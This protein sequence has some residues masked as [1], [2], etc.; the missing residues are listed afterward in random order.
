MGK[1]SS[2]KLL[3]SLWGRRGK[4]LC[5]LCQNVLDAK[6]GMSR[7]EQWLKPS[8]ASRADKKN[9]PSVTDFSTTGRKASKY[10]LLQI[11]SILITY[12]PEITFFKGWMALVRTISSGSKPTELSKHPDFTQF[13]LLFPHSTSEQNQHTLSCFDQIWHNFLQL[14]GSCRS[15]PK[16]HRAVPLPCPGHSTRTVHLSHNSY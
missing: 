9:N 7:P 15:I 10:T 1:P 8:Q 5:A 3:L 13:T 16:K 11:E 2:H 12:D 6:R 4:T 14:K